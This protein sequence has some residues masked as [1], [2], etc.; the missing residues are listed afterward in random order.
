MSDVKKT[1]ETIK[2]VENIV[3]SKYTSRI[4]L[5]RSYEAAGDF[6]ERHK[7]SMRVLRECKTGYM[8]RVF[9]I[10]R[11]PSL[12]QPYGSAETLILGFLE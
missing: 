2:E 10:Y 9:S 12:T 11:Y 8:C 1:F 5:P 6:G 4:P 3:L 7:G